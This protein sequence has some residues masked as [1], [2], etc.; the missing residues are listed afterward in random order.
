MGKACRLVEVIDEAVRERRFG[1]SSDGRRRP[2]ADDLRADV[3]GRRLSDGSRVI[4]R[5]V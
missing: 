5:A 1:C 2:V 3:R 4:S